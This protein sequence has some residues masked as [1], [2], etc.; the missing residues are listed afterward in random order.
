[1]SE[2]F[3]PVLRIDEREQKLPAWAREQLRDLRHRVRRNVELLEVAQ[4]AT[5]ET[6][7]TTMWIDSGYD[8]PL[9]P[10]PPLC[11]VRVKLGNSFARVSVEDDLDVGP[12]VEIRHERAQIGT[13][14]GSSN[15]VTVF[16]LDNVERSDEG[17]DRTFALAILR[18]IEDAGLTRKQ[19]LNIADSKKRELVELA[20]TLR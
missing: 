17:R 5:P 10:I 13:K 18:R 3:D 12:S 14:A 8:Q 19:A 9:V 4:Q 1:M 11:R 16:A 6:A 20:K 7:D 15:V 2:A